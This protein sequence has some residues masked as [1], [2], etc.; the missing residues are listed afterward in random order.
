MSELNVDGNNAFLVAVAHVGRRSAENHCSAGVCLITHT[1]GGF[2]DKQTGQLSSKGAPTITRCHAT[3]PGGG[4][5][6]VFHIGT[7]TVTDSWVNVIN[8]TETPRWFDERCHVVSGDNGAVNVLSE[9]MI[10]DHCLSGTRETVGQRKDTAAAGDS[11]G[12]VNP[13]LNKL[14]LN[15]AGRAH[16]HASLNLCLY[17]C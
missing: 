4:A 14:T 6:T 15:T 8:A 12:D 1:P 3:H 10:C 11:P 17:A 16:F 2:E 7:Q 5:P 13:P 9:V